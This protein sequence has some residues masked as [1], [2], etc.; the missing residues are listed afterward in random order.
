M[1]QFNEYVYFAAIIFG[2]VIYFNLERL[3]DHF[4]TNHFVLGNRRT[5]AKL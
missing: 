1:Y 5:E 3:H 2:L 4:F